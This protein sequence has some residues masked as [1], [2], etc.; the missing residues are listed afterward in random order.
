MVMS[1]TTVAPM[2]ITRR[3]RAA[4]G[5]RP[6]RILNSPGRIKPN[7]P[8]ISQTEMNWRNSAERGLP[9]VN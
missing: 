6:G 8:S 2:T 3:P 1:V 5:V 7:A 9:A 4:S